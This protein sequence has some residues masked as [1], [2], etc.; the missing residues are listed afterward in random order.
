MTS[1][2]IMLLTVCFLISGCGSDCSQTQCGLNDYGE[3]ICGVHCSDGY[4]YG[5]FPQ[6][7]VPHKK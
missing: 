2:A 6:E 3:P 5:W 7:R 1:K 4:V